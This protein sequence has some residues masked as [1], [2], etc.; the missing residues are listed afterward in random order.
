MDGSK[1]PKRLLGGAEYIDFRGSLVD[2]FQTPKFSPDATRIYFETD[3]YAT[4]A[5]I[6][7]IDVA[8][9]KTKLL[10]AGLGV[11]VI[12]TG[13]Y[14]GFLIGIKAPLTL[15]RGRLMVYWLLDP[16]GKEI[17]RIG[18]TDSDLDRF[19]RMYDVR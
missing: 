8:T 18:E 1:P 3:L 16:S 14:R 4:A 15:D 2:G 13:K 11:D 7:V 9:G 6:K 17:T 12:R 19:K 10:F 5:A